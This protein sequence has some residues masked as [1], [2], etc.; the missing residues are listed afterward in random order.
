MARRVW[1]DGDSVAREAR[2]LMERHAGRR[3][4]QLIIVAD[5][6]IELSHER[7]VT[8]V[9]VEQGDDAVDRYIL[10][11]LE[12]QELVVTRDILLAEAVIA[13]GAYVINDR[14]EEFSEATISQRRQERDMMKLLRESGMVRSGGHSY[15]KGD[16]RSFANAFDI[17][18]SKRLQ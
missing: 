18:L 11:R 15:G 17:F 10:D 5:R 3:D 6:R 13:R 8:L 16:L 4:Y 1:V 2:R 14:G 7:S 9:E 12:A